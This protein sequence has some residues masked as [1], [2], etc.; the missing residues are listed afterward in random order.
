M[1]VECWINHC[2]SRGLLSKK[3]S[4]SAHETEQVIKE[5]FYALCLLHCIHK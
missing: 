1:F 3:I 4:F 2:L 5:I